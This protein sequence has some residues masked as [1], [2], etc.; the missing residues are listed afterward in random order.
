LVSV[1]LRI[2]LFGGTFDPPHVGHIAAAVNVRHALLLDRVLMMVAS[3]PYQKSTTRSITP[4]DARLAMTRA[5]CDGVPGLEVSDA[6]IVR[7]G[8][9]YT[10]DTVCDI[11]ASSP[12]VEV[13]VIV[14]GDT[15]ARVE[16]WHRW[17]ELA[18]MVDFVV[19]ARNDDELTLPSS[20]KWTRV[21]T[22]IIECSSTDL[23]RRLREGDD[24]THLLPRTVL[25]VIHARHLYEDDS[26][27]QQVTA[28]TAK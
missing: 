11:R 17:R 3:D 27:R 7:G 1:P 23:R 22:P 19:I 16:T 12:D 14:G 5:A 9:S 15:A 25:G 28:G 4:A 2:G 18:E 21:D 8:Q 6:E 26:S 13:F 24:T 10:F 20:I